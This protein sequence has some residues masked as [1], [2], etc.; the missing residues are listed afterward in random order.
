MNQFIKPSW[1]RKSRQESSQSRQL[2]RFLQGLNLNTVCS[3]ANCPNL[4]E[5]FNQRKA[6]F[7]ILG[8]ICTRSCKYCGITK[9]QPLK[10]NPLE[11]MLIAEAV[12]KM[13]LKHVVITSVT[14]D[15]LSDG[16]SSQFASVI[17]LLKQLKPDLKIEVLIP[18][19]NGTREALENVLQAEPDVVNHNLETVPRLYP[20]LRP[21]ADFN[22]ALK[23]LE[24]IKKYAKWKIPITKSGLIVGL[25]ETDAEIY[26]VLEELKAVS[27]DSVTIGHYL[28]PSRKHLPIQR[29]VSLETFLAYEKYAL[30][31]G[32]KAVASGPFVRSSYQACALFKKT[33]GE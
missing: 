14:R 6:T 5:C 28:P 25:G 26:C 12:Q 15:D 19:F 22:Q 21:A 33:M 3:E 29:H 17:K 7:L 32:F 13:D 4:T 18:D 20:L 2:A 23:L 1:L 16:G 30:K 9:G 8:K 27:C 11:P 24:H 31:L 10:P